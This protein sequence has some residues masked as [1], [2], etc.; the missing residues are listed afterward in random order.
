MKYDS[1]FR[2]PVTR[3]IK[4]GR[5]VLGAGENVG[6]HKT[7]A[8]EEVILVTKGRGALIQEGVTASLESGKAYFV[9]EGTLHDVHNTSDEPLEYVYVVAMLN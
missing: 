5:V 7:E 8:R 9:K 6:E 3:R 4:C 1:I 2:P